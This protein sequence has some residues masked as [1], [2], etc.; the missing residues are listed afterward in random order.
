MVEINNESI[1]LVVIVVVG[2]IILKLLGKFMFRLVGAVV[3]LL[4]I[5]I[6]T[7]FYTNIFSSN[8]DNAIVQKI[9]EKIN[10]LSVIDYQ[11]KHCGKPG[12][13][14]IDS[15]KCEC[16]ID[17]LVKDFKANYT[18]DELNELKKD[19]Q[20]YKKEL[21][22]ALKRNQAVIV[23]KLKEK[24]AIYIWNLMVKDLKKGIVIGEEK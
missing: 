17:P 2:L 10:F 8:Q 20:K 4:G 12:M 23:Q 7:Y 9:E 22:A 13:S 1:I 19:K 5:F 21:V 11:A 15:I 16:L 24:N 14:H 18:E 3:L 6:Y